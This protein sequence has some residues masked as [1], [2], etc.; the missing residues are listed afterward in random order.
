MNQM[1]VRELH[2]PVRRRGEP[3]SPTPRIEFAH[4]NVLAVLIGFG[5]MEQRAFYTESPGCYSSSQDAMGDVCRVL[6]VMA[7][8]GGGI[9]C[10]R[11]SMHECRRAK[12][13]L[14]NRPTIEIESNVLGQWNVVGCCQFHKQVVWVLRVYNR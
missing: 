11:H 3:D 6:P 12:R 14:G 13:R 1:A 4:F 10:C 8:R 2:R 5:A 7:K 9:L